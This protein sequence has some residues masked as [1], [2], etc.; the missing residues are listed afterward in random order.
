M[1]AFH[2]HLRSL[3]GVESDLEMLAKRLNAVTAQESSERHFITMLAGELDLRNRLL[4]Y[5][6]CGHPP[7]FVMDRDGHV[8]K[9]LES[10]QL[11]LGVL[12]DTAYQRQGPIVLQSGDVLAL[13]TDGILETTSPAGVH[14]GNDGIVNVVRENRRK[15]AAE[16]IRALRLAAEEFQAHAKFEDDVTLVIA[17]VL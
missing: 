3:V 6:R 7:A 4:H 11:P 13:F 9:W 15:S 10:G 17:K 16:I 12:T 2:A 8:T 1:A 14:F 5:V